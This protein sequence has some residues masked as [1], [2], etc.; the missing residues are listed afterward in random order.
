MQVAPEY[1]Q[2]TCAAIKLASSYALSIVV[3]GMG[4]GHWDR[5]FPDHCCD[6]SLLL[7]DCNQWSILNE[8]VQAAESLCMCSATVPIVLLTYRPTSLIHGALQSSV[9]CKM[10]H[11]V[12]LTLD[13][14]LI[15]QEC[16]WHEIILIVQ[17]Y[18]LCSD[19]L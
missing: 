8:L 9:C 12:G 16:V 19:L 15:L 10:W 7:I 6:C 14:T 18:E 5:C 11:V 13:D 4:D 1:E 2:E 3:I 17:L